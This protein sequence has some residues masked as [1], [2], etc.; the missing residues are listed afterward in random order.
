MIGPAGPG[1]EPDLERIR[2]DVEA[3]AAMGRSSA[4]QGERASAAWL[5]GRLGELGVAEVSVEPYRYQGSYALAHS[6]H[7][8][9]ALLAARIGG[10]A[11][12]ALGLGDALLL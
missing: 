2:G 5:A 9:A 4:R 10:T 6:V 12:A 8:A 7:N 3:L 1:Y 11:G